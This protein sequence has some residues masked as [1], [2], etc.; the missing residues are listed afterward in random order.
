MA[1]RKPN[2]IGRKRGFWGL[3]PPPKKI[4]S[5]GQRQRVALD[6]LMLLDTKNIKIGEKL[7]Y[8]T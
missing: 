5:N 8:L 7:R 4:K 2:S 6:E 1:Q 3:T